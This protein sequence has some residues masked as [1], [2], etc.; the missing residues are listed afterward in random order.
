MFH[1]VLLGFLNAFGF[2]MPSLY[3]LKTQKIAIFDYLLESLFLDIVFTLL[4]GLV[5]MRR[6]SLNTIK[7]IVPLLISLF[8]FSF[9]ETVTVTN[10]SVQNILAFKFIDTSKILS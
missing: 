9:H 3:L 5:L 8:G 1:L 4:F 2:I 10:S 7:I 6:S